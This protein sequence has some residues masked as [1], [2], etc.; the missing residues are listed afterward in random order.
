MAST[1]ARGG[2]ER[3][4]VEVKDKILG[5]HKLLGARLPTPLQDLGAPRRP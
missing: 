4:R 5:T 3:P 1:R 2:A